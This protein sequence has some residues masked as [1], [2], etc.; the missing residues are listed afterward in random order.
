[1]ICHGACLSQQCCHECNGLQEQ[2][3]KR[4]IIMT[5]KACQ[6]CCL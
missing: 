4:H 2:Q 6:S 3:Q 5:A 1:L